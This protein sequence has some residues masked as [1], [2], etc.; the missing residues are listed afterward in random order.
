[1]G[2]SAVIYMVLGIL[3]TIYLL[4]TDGPI[5]AVTAVALSTSSFG[6]G[7]LLSSWVGSRYVEKYDNARRQDSSL[8]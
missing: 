5:S 6:M 3:L 7:A 8:R 2:V 1:V 4:T